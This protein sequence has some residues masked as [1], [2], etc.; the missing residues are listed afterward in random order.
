MVKKTI[1]A[2]TS[3]L[4]PE[5]YQKIIFSA[6]QHLDS[7]EFKNSFKKHGFVC[8]SNI[9]LSLAALKFMIRHSKDPKDKVA[10]AGWWFMNV[11]AHF[12]EIIVKV[13]GPDAKENFDLTVDLMLGRFE[14]MNLFSNEFDDDGPV[15][16]RKDI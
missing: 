6:S 7:K 4:C 12:Q 11:M 8:E 2:A 13:V 9:E 1:K 16:L 5:H 10:L 14:Q 3:K 15:S